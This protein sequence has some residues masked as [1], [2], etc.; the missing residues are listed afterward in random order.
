MEDANRAKEQR[1]ALQRQIVALH[2]VAVPAFGAAMQ[3]VVTSDDEQWEKT[4]H[5]LLD[6]SGVPL[7]LDEGEVT[8]VMREA[9]ATA[10]RYLR[11]DLPA[12]EVGERYALTYARKICAMAPGGHVFLAKDPL[13]R[14]CHRCGLPWQEGQPLLAERPRVHSTQLVAPPTP[15]EPKA[16]TFLT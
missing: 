16:S 5:W 4:R 1:K 12:A 9:S 15:R 14:L 7:A 2:A 11:D 3:G 10:L 6:M 8:R 13:P